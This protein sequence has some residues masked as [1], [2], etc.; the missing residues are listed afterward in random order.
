MNIADFIVARLCFHG[1]NTAFAVTGGG[2]MFLNNAC[3]AQPKLKNFY[4]HH[5]QAC[6]MA[7][8]GY[9]RVAEKPAIVNVTTGPG[10]INSLNGVFGAFTDSIPMIILSGQVKKE[11]ISDL[12][13]L[14]SL[15]QLGDQEAR[16]IEMVKPIC[17][18]VFFIEN[19]VSLVDII[20][21]AYF[22][23]TTG[24]PG[25]VW[26]EVPID[27][28]S[29]EISLD[30][31]TCEINFLQE[32]IQ[33]QGYENKLNQIIEL[34]KES[35]RPVILSGTGIKLSKTINE[36]VSLAEKLSFPVLTAW[37]H[38]SFPN[39]HRLY[40]GRP[41]TI[42]TR[43]ANLI[44]QNSDLIIVLGSRLNIRQ[45]SYNFKDF[46][47]N[48]KIIWVDIDS[49]EFKKPHIKY[50]IA[51]QADL[52]SFI[53]DLLYKIEDSKLEINNLKWLEWCE[54][55][56]LKYSPKYE[57][58]KE[59]ENKVNPYKFIFKLFNLIPEDSIIACG[60]ASACIIPF[61]VG[62]LKNSQQMFS[63]SGSASMGY[64]L[65]AAIGA[66]IAAPEKTTVCIA[67]DGSI[68]MNLQELETI[69]R[70]NL[71]IKII[72]IANDG[73]L[74]IKQTQSNFFNS[75]FGADPESGVSFP[76]FN[77]IFDSFEIHNYKVV[78]LNE[79]IYTLEQIFET[80]NPTG[81]V[82]EADPG[83]EFEP[84]IKSRKVGDKIMTPQLDDMF[85][86]LSSDELEL[87]RK[88]ALSI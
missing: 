86:H 43:S 34:I 35:K 88:S 3:A 55:N 53:P 45:T 49:N 9:A 64:E 30:P 7:A 67:G 59:G 79:E 77:R 1:I 47:K 38:D 56:K 36:L 81:I 27:V 78:N 69:R 70:L 37:S 8:E 32:I 46:A 52:K 76:D 18:K 74:S 83:Q 31:Y 24:R 21:E 72:L 84:R 5:E 4:L 23:A 41:G 20:D 12:Q 57:D 26:I 40:F 75:K 58:Y 22:T 39:Q 28:Q 71:N 16:T 17:K 19:F 51:L 6:A 33:E 11:T 66:A 14:N 85:P 63:N 82:V 50:E 60:N 2:A 44:F 13:N 15:R 80:K 65:P 42:G 68:M 62:K 10:A 87:I 73:Y 54:E 48:S 29:T 25:P 61:Q